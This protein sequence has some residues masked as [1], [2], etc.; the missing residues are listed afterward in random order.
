M[1][2]Q[3]H[4]IELI[5]PRQL[6]LINEGRLGSILE[7]N[8]VVSWNPCHFYVQMG[9]FCSTFQPF[10]ALSF[11][12]ICTIHNLTSINQIT[13]NIACRLRLIFMPI[14]LCLNVMWFHSTCFNFQYLLL[15]HLPSISSSIFLIIAQKVLIV[16]LI[17]SVHRK[18]V[19]YESIVSRICSR[20]NEYLFPCLWFLVV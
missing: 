19:D 10:L 2:H 15:S 18:V 11:I 1:P 6:N 8:N 7:K 4:A 3:F 12:R 5:N 13:Y 20:L 16:F 14:S 17:P 9:P